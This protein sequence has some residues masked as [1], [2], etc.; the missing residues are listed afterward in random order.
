MVTISKETIHSDFQTKPDKSINFRQVKKHYE[1]FPERWN[2]VFKFLVETDLKTIETGRIDLSEDVFTV[3]SEYETKKPEDALFESHKEYID[4]QYVI[5]GEELIGLTNDQSIKIATPY[6]YSNDI[7]FY[8]FD[9][10]KLLPAS[11]ENYFIFFPEDIHRPCIKTS[12]KSMVK[13]IVLKIKV[14]N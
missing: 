9:G 11:P 8:Q 7:T 3:V 12:K 14:G 6:S 10:G 1:Q 2:L 4:L 5:S 13:K